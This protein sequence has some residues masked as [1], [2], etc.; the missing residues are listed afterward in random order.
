MILEIFGFDQERLTGTGLDMVDMM[1]I[2]YIIFSSSSTDMLHETKDK[3]NYTW[4]NHDKFK[5]DLP[6]LELTEP[7]LRRR[8]VKLKESGMIDSIVISN[9]MKGKRTYYGITPYC[10]SLRK[11]RV[12]EGYRLSDDHV[13]K[14][15]RGENQVSKMIP[16]TPS[17]SIKNDTSDNQTNIYNQTNSRKENTKEKKS[18]SKDDDLI[19][20]LDSYDLIQNYPE[21]KEHFIEF[22]QARREQKEP[23]TSLALKKAINTV[24]GFFNGDVDKAIRSIDKSIL[25]GYKGLFDPDDNDKVKYRHKVE[26]NDFFGDELKRISAEKSLS[27]NEGQIEISFTTP[28][29][30]PTN[31]QPSGM[32]EEEQE[33]FLRECGI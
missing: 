20:Q 30:L 24:K 22:I 31:N 1:I 16:D 15:I 19:E 5:E 18:K 8:L 21:L 4:I 3:R 23:L 14:M 11:S 13:S 9:E 10:D 26:S 6:F 2:H 28:L 27:K 7:T 29:A 12:E 33:A 32:T 25:C 17:P